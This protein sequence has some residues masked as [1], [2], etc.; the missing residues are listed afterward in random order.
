[1]KYILL[2]LSIQEKIILTL[3][4]L[5]FTDHSGFHRT[6]VIHRMYSIQAIEI[7]NLIYSACKKNDYPNIKANFYHNIKTGKML[8]SLNLYYIDSI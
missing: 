5:D 4:W 8:W 6:G 1:M 2:S 3:L 7:I